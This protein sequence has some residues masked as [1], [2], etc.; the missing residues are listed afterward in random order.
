MENL[1]KK[2]IENKLPETHFLVDT[3][4]S[5]ASHYF[6]IA[7]TKFSGIEFKEDD[8]RLFKGRIS[9][10]D[11]ICGRSFANCE[12]LLTYYRSELEVNLEQLGFELY[13]ED[14][15]ENEINAFLGETPNDVSVEF[16]IY[17]PKIETKN[18]KFVANLI[19]DKFISEL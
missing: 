9:T 12:I 8:N 4:S 1:I 11:A 7:E 14:E 5:K 3:C 19:A 2:A 15:I 16:D 17:N 10:H 6:Y 13:D 18:Y